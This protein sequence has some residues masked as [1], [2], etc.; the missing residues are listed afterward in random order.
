MPL[1]YL[2]LNTAMT[3]LWPENNFAVL[4]WLF[5]CLS[6]QTLGGRVCYFG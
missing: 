2:F 3:P 6:V 1:G 4:G 5:E